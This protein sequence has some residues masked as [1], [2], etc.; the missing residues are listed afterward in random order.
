M[1]RGEA[2]RI[3]AIARQ[4]SVVDELLTQFF[5]QTDKSDLLETALTLERF[6]DERAIRPLISALSDHNVDRRRAAA[7]ALGW[8]P[9]TRS[10]VAKALSE[11]LTDVSQ[12]V[13]VREE[14]AES[15]A[16]RSS[17]SSIPSL[18]SVLHDP[19]VQIRFWSVFALG[20]I[21]NRRNGHSYPEVVTPLET[22]LSDH[23]SLNEKWWTVAREALAMLGQLS[24][25]IPKWK[26]QFRQELRQATETV[27]ATAEDHRW[28][29][30][31]SHCA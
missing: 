5:S 31:Y 19:S 15:L 30:F 2:G 13:A 16:Y 21:R 28:A 9:R 3:L 22:M 14:A 6:E 29:Q 25:P 23:H 27:D 20:N 24:P 1:V 12:P 8:M 10:C 11:A 7:R 26:E 18:I 4:C 17:R